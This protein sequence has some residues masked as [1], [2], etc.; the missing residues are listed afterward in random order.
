L[1]TI[2][3]VGSLTASSDSINPPGAHTDPERLLSSA[4]GFAALADAAAAA[5]GS[6][7]RSG[8]AQAALYFT[9]AQALELAV[10]AWL[11]MSGVSLA[12]LKKYGHDLEDLT[13][14]AKALGLA[15]SAELTPR[16]LAVLNDVYSGKKG[17]QYPRW[18]GIALPPSREVRTAVDASI[19]AAALTVRGGTDPSRPGAAIRPDA[20]W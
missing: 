3:G 7:M 13:A 9:L 5:G 1:A 11:R 2:T 6:V 20:R 17:L 8:S 14:A 18:D 16:S 4:E 15:P 19:A 10:K 12:E